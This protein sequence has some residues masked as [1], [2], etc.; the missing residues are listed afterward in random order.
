MLV[1]DK[2]IKNQFDTLPSGWAYFALK[3]SEGYL[4]SGYTAK[5][6]RKLTFLQNK[7][8]EGGLYKE[9]WA[10]AISVE[11]TLHTQNM[12]ALIQHKAFLAENVPE[13]QHRLLPWADYAYLALDATRYPFITVVEH[14]NDDWLYLG[15]FRSRFFLADL[16]D[17]LSRILKL[18]YCESGTFPCE[19]F[20]QDTCRGW[21]LSLAPAKESGAEDGLDKLDALLKE[22][23]LHPE[24]GILELVQ[25]ERDHYF[26]DLEFIKASLLDDEIEL[27]AKYRDWLNFLY[28][29]K[30]LEFE[31]DNVKVSGGRIVWAKHGGREFNFALDSTAYRANEALAMNLEIV[32]ESR[33]LY[34]YK[35]KMAITKPDSPSMQ[36]A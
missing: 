18:P 1:F 28:V 26:D 17:T 31:T 15:P 12:D 29:G 30:Q 21:C 10:K 34:D 36:D 33:I 19:K 4:Y 23:Y 32:D 13:Y 7:A 9:M 3:S 24:N 6:S 16:I 22:A 2:H 8:E 25:K 11:Y 14:T 5:L 27:L 35:V 20:D